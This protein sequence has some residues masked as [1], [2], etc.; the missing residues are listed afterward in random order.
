MEPTTV[1]RKGTLKN[2]EVYENV[3]G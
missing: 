3:P 1:G 2:P